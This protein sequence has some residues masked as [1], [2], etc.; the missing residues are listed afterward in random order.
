MKTDTRYIIYTVVKSKY[1]YALLS[2]KLLISLNK[3]I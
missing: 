3:F 2:V 1:L